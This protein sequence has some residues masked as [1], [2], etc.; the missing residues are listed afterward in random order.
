M[1]SV[2]RTDGEAIVPAYLGQM[3]LE[4]SFVNSSPSPSLTR[5][6]EMVEN[7]AM[8]SRR[9][10]TLRSAATTCLVGI[11]LVQ[12]IGLPFLFAQ[13]RQLAVLSMAALALC[14]GLG[15]ALAAAPAGGGRQLWRVVAAAAVVVLAGWA[16]PHVVA[17]P[18]L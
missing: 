10:A 1:R 16:V 11:A 13:G 7:S 2:V 12:A 8:L 14:L 15:M 3:P 17:V 4:P 9:E 6:P 5:R 18:E